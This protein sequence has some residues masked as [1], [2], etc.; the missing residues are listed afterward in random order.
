MRKEQR[1][2][3][4]KILEPFRVYFSICSAK[5]RAAI[6]SE[7]NCWGFRRRKRDSA[8]A[9]LALFLVVGYGIIPSEKAVTLNVLRGLRDNFV[10]GFSLRFSL[11]IKVLKCLFFR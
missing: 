8:L 9:A 1:L 5:Q 10:E 2:N 11:F 4:L 3:C 6:K 7:R